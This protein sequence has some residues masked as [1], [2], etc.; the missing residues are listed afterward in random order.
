LIVIAPWVEDAKRNLQRYK[1]WN[2]NSNA[3]DESGLIWMPKPY[4]EI[5][6]AGEFQL[7]HY[8]VPPPRPYSGFNDF[9]F[10]QTGRGG[11]LDAIRWRL[12]KYHPKAKDVIQRLIRY[13]PAK[14]YDSPDN[15]G[16]ILTRAIIERWVDEADVPV[17]ICPIPMY[18]HIEGDSSAKEVTARFAELRQPDA[19]AMS[20][21]PFLR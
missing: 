10:E 3:D 21:M 6:E 15:P 19:G 12:R 2:R 8:P 16:W 18:Q 20:S 13:Q 5:D 1:L 9:E 11:R 7:R 17:L 14:L 4:F